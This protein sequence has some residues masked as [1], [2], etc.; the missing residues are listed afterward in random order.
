VSLVRRPKPPTIPPPPPVDIDAAA[1]QA[2]EELQRVRERRGKR[3]TR[4][5]Q[6]A[7][8]QNNFARSFKNALGSHR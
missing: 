6:H 2:M 7:I 3:V 1:T 8:A 5:T 4:L